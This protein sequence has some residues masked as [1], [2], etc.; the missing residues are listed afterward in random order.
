MWGRR[1]TN[2]FHF[3]FELKKQTHQPQKAKTSNNK[4]AFEVKS[5]QK[6]KTAE[7]RKEIEK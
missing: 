3:H 1:I 7:G 4:R 5:E 6:G 2:L